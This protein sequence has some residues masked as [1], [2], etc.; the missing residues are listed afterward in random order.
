MEIKSNNKA[1]IVAENGAIYKVTCESCEEKRQLYIDKTYRDIVIFNL[2]Q[3]GVKPINFMNEN[4]QV[5]P[6]E[7]EF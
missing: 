1:L 7:I 5:Q 6:L 2:I 4:M 3:A